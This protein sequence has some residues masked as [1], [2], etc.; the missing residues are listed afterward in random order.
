MWSTYP[1]LP[2]FP[3]YNF[4]ASYS[5][6]IALFMIKKVHELQTYW[7]RSAPSSADHFDIASSNLRLG[8]IS[9]EIRPTVKLFNHIPGS[10]HAGINETFLAFSFSFYNTTSS[11]HRCVFVIPP[12][13]ISHWRLRDG[14]CWK[15]LSVAHEVW[16]WR[17]RH[18]TQTDGRNLYYRQ[19]NT[20][21]CARASRRL[22]VSHK[23]VGML[24]EADFSCL[25]V[26][27]IY[28]LLFTMLL[29]V[30]SSKLSLYCSLKEVAW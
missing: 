12:E 17:Y 10:P 21:A 6:S 23:S 28:L 2:T 29:L 25:G 26:Q 19:E 7:R 5:H 30:P 18:Q 14:R 3:L 15:P 16:M 8:H 1:T 11:S 22:S 4:L 9:Y 20:L 13:R 27:A 24:E